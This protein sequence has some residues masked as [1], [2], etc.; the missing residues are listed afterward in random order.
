MKFIV[1]A[2]LPQVLAEFLRY[3]GYDAIHTL[4]LAAKNQ[5]GDDVIRQITVE[6]GGILVTKDGDFEASFRLKQIPPKLLLIRTG[7]IP[8]RDLLKLFAANLTLLMQLLDANQFVELD[9]E[10]ITVHA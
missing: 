7:N 9:R 10:K 1:D 6:E 4:D 2:Q 3:R 8:N 5:T